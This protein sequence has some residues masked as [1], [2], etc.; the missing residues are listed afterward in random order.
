M[1]NYQNDIFV[2][3]S[4]LK[5]MYFNSNS[6]LGKLDIIKTYNET[7]SPDILCITE[8]KIDSSFDDNELLGPDFTVAR[9]D[10]TQGGGGVLI[11]FRN[12]SSLQILKTEKGPGE[13][14]VLTLKANYHFTLNLI[15]FYRPPS[16]YSL[17]NMTNILNDYCTSF[18]AIVVGDFNLP[19]INWCVSS[20]K[21]LVKICSKRKSIHQ[22]AI[23][24][25]RSVDL[26]QLIHEPT[27][28]KG[29]T[30]DLVF[31]NS[32]IKND[33]VVACE[34][35]PGISDHSVILVGGKFLNPTSSVTNEPTKCKLNFKKISYPDIWEPFESLKIRL[36]ENQFLSTEDMWLDFKETIF[37]VISESVPTLLPRP[38][39]KPWMTR[40]LLRLIRARKR[41]FER[42]KKYPT[43][44]NINL[45]LQLSK[46][47][48][49]EV[50]MAK[51]HFLKKHIT[52][53]LGV[54]NSKPLFNLINRSRGQAN[55]ISN[56]EDCTKDEIPEKLAEYFASVYSKSSQGNFPHFEPE[57]ET[58]M[59]NFTI[60]E[61]GV[62]NLLQKLDKRKATGLDGI[63]SYLLRDFGTYIPAFVPCITRIFN[64]SLRSHTVP[65]DWR[66]AR[67]CPIF[68]SGDRCQAENYRPISLTSV[69]SKVLEHIIVSTM[70]KHIDD[71]NLLINAQHGFRSGFGT[72]TQLLHVVH[73]ASQALDA[74]QEYHIVSFDFAKAFDK[75]PHDLLIYKIRKYKFSNQIVEW[76]KAWLDER[77]TVVAVNGVVS[78]EHGVGSGVPQGSVLGPLLFLL[79]VN[80]L[81]NGL[82]NTECR[83]Y[84]D[85]TLLCMNLSRINFVELQ[86]NV[87]TLERWALDWGM[88]FNPSKCVHMQLGGGSEDY[89]RPSLMLNGIK[90]PKADIIKYLGLYINSS[91]KWSDQITYVCKKANKTLGMLRRCLNYASPKTAIL[92]FNTVVRPILEYASQVWSPYTQCRSD[93]LERIQRRAVRWAFKIP[94]FCSVSDINDKNN[95]FI[96]VSDIMD[97]NNISTLSSRRDKLD[98]T[99]LEKLQL[100]DY[101]INIRD[102]VLFNDCHFT[103]GNTLNPHF[104][105]NQYKYSFYNRMRSKV[106]CL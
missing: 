23:E 4:D 20:G 102:Y 68:K 105:T 17:E 98:L 74:K 77:T 42:R 48:K 11:A 84:A 52:D 97:K 92:A 41:L 45:E 63:S 15:T 69:T 64:E 22:A 35:I 96:S 87:T 93:D 79:Y 12:N 25:F 99:F 39:G 103:R 14:I 18:P 55:Q 91:L 104:N 5:I 2:D 94:K 9:N 101:K 56:L 31:I 50:K 67:V 37:R 54:G 100:G 58:Q 8:T 95:K 72:T 66:S 7:Y 90:I 26:F 81:P 85:D 59:S 32:A 73:K 29:N 40:N 30:L 51:T 43:N 1:A 21:G 106:K 36:I 49:H 82:S 65:K 10:R 86:N 16:E 70:W 24:T 83:L 71:N 46:R 19:D 61:S 75:V 47:I 80:D 88:T 34:V 76:L 38:K 6:I 13:S 3:L 89:C 33:F 57:V 62:Q 53:E 44:D 78:S 28:A 60:N 27:H